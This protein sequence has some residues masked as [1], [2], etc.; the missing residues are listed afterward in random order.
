M[1]AKEEGIDEND[2]RERLTKAA[3]AAAADR[4]DGSARTLWPM[5]SARSCCR[6]G[7]LRCREHLADLEH[8][9]S[10]VG[11][12]GYAQRLPAQR[13]QGRGVQAVPGDVGQLRQGGV[14]VQLMRVE[15]A[16][17]AAERPA[18]RGTQVFGHHLDG[19]TGE[20]DFGEGTL[21]LTRAE[22]RAWLAE[23]AIRKTP[24]PGQGRP[25][26]G[27]SLWFRQEVQALPRGV[28]V[29]G[30]Q[31]ASAYSLKSSSL[32]FE[33]FTSSGMLAPP[34]TGPRWPKVPSR[35]R[36][37]RERS[38]TRDTRQFARR[39]PSRSP[40]ARR[41]HRAVYDNI[42]DV[43]QRDGAARGVGQPVRD[44]LRSI[45]RVVAEVIPIVGRRPHASSTRAVQ[46]ADERI[47]GGHCSN[48]VATVIRAARGGNGDVAERAG[49]LV[50]PAGEQ[51]VWS[52]TRPPP[53]K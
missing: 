42:V 24:R 5:S 43:E 6:T 18:A 46:L 44:S 7:P 9:R 50:A 47:Q 2:I 31:E 40:C 48:G 45:R 27:L 32:S 53:M 21:T 39:S 37:A 41:R 22:T 28:C 38:S 51:V 20:D 17:Q 14:T 3:D 34:M 13:V 30:A 25:Q 12:R 35:R 36:T 1:G 49:Q 29:G 16:R 4:A 8:L 23:R 11:F 52:S 19:T 10:V 26:R 15:R 33:Y